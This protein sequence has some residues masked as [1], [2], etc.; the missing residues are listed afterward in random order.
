VRGYVLGA[1]F[2]VAAIV[3]FVWQNNSQVTINYLI[4]TSPKISIALVALV[5]AVVGALI[6]FFVD[7]I[8]YFKVVRKL[9][10]V[11][12]D[13]KKL[14]KQLRQFQDDNAQRKPDNGR[15]KV[16]T[17]DGVKKQDNITV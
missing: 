17:E 7:G 3:L 12:A 1:L 6:T 16:N 4:W 14:N 9:R 5:A 13:N 11:L 2:F 15:V 10:E 8:R